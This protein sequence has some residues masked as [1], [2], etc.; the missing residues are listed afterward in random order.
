LGDEVLYQ[1]AREAPQQWT[2][3]DAF[4]NAGWPADIPTPKELGAFRVKDTIDGLNSGLISSRLRFTR[5]GKDTR[6]GWHFMKV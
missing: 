5:T 6:I 3:L 1:F 4:E 2:V